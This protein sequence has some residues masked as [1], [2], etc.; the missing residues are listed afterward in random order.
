MNEAEQQA[1]QQM[2]QGARGGEMPQKNSAQ[3]PSQPTLGDVHA[4]LTE[5]LSRWRPETPEGKAYNDELTM[6][7]DQLG[8][9]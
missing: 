5:M 1:I 3:Q 8:G 7:V 4:K 2:V 6:F 9:V